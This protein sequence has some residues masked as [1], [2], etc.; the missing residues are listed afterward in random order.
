MIGDY[1]MGKITVALTDET[2]KKLRSF[3]AKKPRCILDDVIEASVKEYLE[4]QD[5]E[6][7]GSNE[8]FYSSP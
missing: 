2:E 7:I 4:K 1:L 5:Y 8:V 3:V 6:H